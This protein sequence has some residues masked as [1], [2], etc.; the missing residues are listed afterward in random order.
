MCVLHKLFLTDQ[1]F[2]L[3]RFC[4]FKSFPPINNKT[5]TILFN[6]CQWTILN[7]TKETYYVIMEQLLSFKMALEVGCFRCA[8]LGLHVGRQVVLPLATGKRYKQLT[9]PPESWLA[10]L[11]AHFPFPLKFP[12]M[13]TLEPPSVNTGRFSLKVPIPVDQSSS[14]MVVMRLLNETA[15]ILNFPQMTL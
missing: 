4:L 7:N 6:D 8:N 5:G 3:C 12:V 9:K 15:L 11:L 13:L 2:K 10:T 1:I 14:K